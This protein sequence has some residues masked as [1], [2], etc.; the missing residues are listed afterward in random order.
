MKFIILPAFKSCW[1]W[2]VVHYD[3]NISSAPFAS[4]LRL[5]ELN[6]E[7][8]AKSIRSRAWQNW[9]LYPWKPFFPSSNL[10][11]ISLVVLEPQYN[12][13]HLTFLD[14]NHDIVLG[15]VAVIEIQQ[16]KAIIL[17]SSFSVIN[18][19]RLVTGIF[20]PKPTIQSVN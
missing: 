14:M 11:I 6:S 20:S 16:F 5:W 17:L 12:N 15:C 18:S 8:W 3:F 9:A 13:A 7:T 10:N 2:V 19:T 1:W 4:E